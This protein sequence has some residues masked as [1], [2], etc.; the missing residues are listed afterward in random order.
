MHN[1]GLD[2]HP[3]LRLVHTGVTEHTVRFEEWL[4]EQNITINVDIRSAMACCHF[5]VEERGYELIN[6]Q[7]APCV[8]YGGQ[9]TTSCYVDGPQGRNGKYGVVK[10]PHSRHLGAPTIR[11]V[12]QSHSYQFYGPAPAALAL[13][14]NL[15]ARL[16]AI[17]VTQLTGQEE[18]RDCYF[19]YA[20]AA[21]LEVYRAASHKDSLRGR[22]SRQQEE[23]KKEV[24]DEEEVEDE[25]EDLSKGVSEIKLQ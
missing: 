21:L 9:P 24:Q 4:Q 20:D 8:M 15:T 19:S 13:G 14:Q 18:L 22:F 16:E 10:T 6:H 3:E 11:P 1:H 17:A 23:M 2:Y 5:L 25:S 12:C 7:M